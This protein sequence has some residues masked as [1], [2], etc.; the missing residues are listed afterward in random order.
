MCERAIIYDWCIA[1]G[2]YDLAGFTESTLKRMLAG[3]RA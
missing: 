3:L 1:G 2:S